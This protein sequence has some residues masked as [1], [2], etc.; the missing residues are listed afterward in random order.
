MKRSTSYALIGLMVLFVAVA[1]ESDEGDGG[2]GNGADTT[3]GADT[4]AD[5]TDPGTD[6]TDPGGDSVGADTTDPDTSTGMPNQARIDEAVAAC[7]AFAEATGIDY[8]A[9]CG[10]PD[11]TTGHA[12]CD[13]FMCSYCYVLVGGLGNCESLPAMCLG[14]ATPSIF[15]PCDAEMI[16]C[17]QDIDCEAHDLAGGSAVMGECQADVA[18]CQEQYK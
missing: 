9:T 17:V 1:C 4:V 3:A 7:D 18:A 16:F 12:D 14:G 6:S 5:S 10:Q 11:Q 13:W 8:M 15:P 2:G